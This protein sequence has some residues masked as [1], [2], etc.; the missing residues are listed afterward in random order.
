MKA[1]VGWGVGVVG[2]VCLSLASVASAVNIVTVPVGNPGNADDTEGDGYGGVDYTYNIG[3]FEVTAGQYTDFLNAVADTDTYGLYNTYMDTANDQFGCNIKRTGSAGSYT[4]N[5]ALDWADRPV[6]YVSWGD[7]ARFCN[8]LENGQP[9]GA[10]GLSTT[11]DGSYYLNGATSN[12]A[13]LAV[14]READATW[15]I[16][17]EDE[18]Y[19]AAYYD[20]ASDVYY[21]YPTGTDATPSND[22]VGP[23]PG[24]NATFYDSGYTIG[25]PYYR[26]EVGAHENS[27]SPYDTF[28]QGGNVWEWNEAVI[29]GSYR[30]L[31]GGSVLDVDYDLHAA[32]RYYDFYPSY[33]DN[34]IGFRVA[35][36]PEP[37]TVG[38]LGLGMLA[39]LRK[40]RK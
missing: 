19:K 17:S 28:D 39:A 18:W 6:N 33:E 11:E 10:Q 1:S 20:G 8:W 3:K 40:R 4:Y 7:A 2:A 26:T 27:E 24:N 30:G 16:P 34:V 21:D 9:I 5:V 13:L 22:L 37:G 32:D 36:V 35:E 12:A 15:V 29:V 25:S 23:D 14:T 38:L 31:R